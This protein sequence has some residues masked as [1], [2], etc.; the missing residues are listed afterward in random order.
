MAPPPPSTETSQLRLLLLKT[1]EDVQ[2]L[3]AQIKQ[4]GGKTSAAA[5]APWTVVDLRTL[6][7]KNHPW[8]VCTVLLL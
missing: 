7:R 5:A 2:T 3:R 8:S 1:L 4:V 6:P